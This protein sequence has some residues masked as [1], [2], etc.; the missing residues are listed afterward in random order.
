MNIMNKKKEINEVEGNLCVVERENGGTTKKDRPHGGTWRGGPTPKK[1]LAENNVK[2]H[3]M[4]FFPT[5]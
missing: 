4:V 1:T 3:N 2:S 5:N